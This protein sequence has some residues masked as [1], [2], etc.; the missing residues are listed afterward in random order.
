M[1]AQPLLERAKARAPTPARPRRRALSPAEHAAKLEAQR[2]NNALEILANVSTQANDLPVPPPVL[3]I[4][5]RKQGLP[6]KLPAAAFELA[7]QVYYLQHGS[8]AQCARAVIASGLSDSKNPTVVADRLRTWWAREQWPRR[9]PVETFRLRDANFDGGLYRGQRTCIGEATGSGPAPKGKKCEQSALLDSDY[10]YHHDAREEYVQARAAQ[11]KLLAAARRSDMVDITPFQQWMEHERKRLLAQEH[12]RRRVHPNQTGWGLLAA[13]INVDLTV[14]GRMRSGNHNG[15]AARAGI[16]PTKTIRASTLVRYLA[17]TQTTFQ[18]IYGFDPPAA[19]ANQARNTCPNCGGRKYHQ[20]K[21]CRTC[22]EATAVQCSYVNR[23][24]RRC[25][26]KTTHS[27]GSCGAC[28]R[29][30]ERQP[31][32]N[33]GRPTWVST[34]MLILAAGQ[35]C[36]QANLAWVARRMWAANAAGVREVFKSQKSLTSG[37]VKQFRKREITTTD[38]ARAFQQQLIAKHGE[39]TWP[40]GAAPIE[41]AGMVPFA[42]FKAWLAERLEEVGSY[43][44]LAQRIH[45]NPDNISKWLRGT[46][47]KTTVRRA[48]VDQALDA[49]GAGTTFADLYLTEVSP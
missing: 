18:D 15:G 47:V 17:P 16:G 31:K 4:I 32:P 7:R 27:S 36:E 33:P 38:A 26:H 46:C 13:A 44:K 9:G 14:I 40:Q 45:M 19:G 21:L 35:Y 20:S 24:G 12:Q 22:H 43:A 10:C 48:T 39:T 5:P 30:I 6:P 29:I 42:P 8:L 2:R 11:A 3:E 41:A 49:F 23:A 37:L 25:T 1:A 28:R 34:P